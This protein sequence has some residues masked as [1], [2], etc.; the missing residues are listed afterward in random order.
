MKMCRAM[1]RLMLSTLA[2]IALVSCAQAD[3]LSNAGFDSLAGPSPCGPATLSFN[4]SSDEAE[5]KV[6]SADVFTNP[7]DETPIRQEVLGAHALVTTGPTCANV[8]GGDPAQYWRANW[9]G[10]G[11]WF[12]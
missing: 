10:G 1:L 9:S 12:I 11:V 7:G 8:P 4:F 5:V 6:A 2:L 3:T